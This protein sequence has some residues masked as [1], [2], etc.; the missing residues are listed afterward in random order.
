MDL[1]EVLSKV[2]VLNYDNGRIFTKVDRLEAIG[3]CLWGSKYRRI[4]P[5][6]LFHLYSPKTI[7]SIQEQVIIVSSHIDCT[8]SITTCFTKLD[9]DKMLHGTYDNAITNAAIVY[10]MQ[11]G[12]LPD[13]V[14]VAFT[15]DE[16][17]DS[18]GAKDVIKYIQKKKIQIECVVVLDVTDMGWIDKADFTVE[19]NFWSDCLGQKIIGLMEN[20]SY[21][22]Y[23]VPSD[24]DNIPTYINSNHIIPIEAEMDESWEYDERNVEC[25]SFCLPIY[26]QMHSNDGVLARQTSFENYT[27]MLGRILMHSA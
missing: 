9:T 16:E 1:M 25:F 15:G 20:S 23:F 14:L 21:K 19:N 12:N 24:P 2:S 17:R 11:L 3:S 13:N 7:N 8:E 6:G 5:Q 10:L 4:N 26:G 27:E 18:N 22:W